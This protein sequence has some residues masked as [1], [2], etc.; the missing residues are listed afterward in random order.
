[1]TNHSTTRVTMKE[2]RKYDFFLCAN[3][4]ALAYRP[5]ANALMDSDCSDFM[6]YKIP[7]NGNK[8]LLH[9]E[10]WDDIIS[11]PEATYEALHLNLSKKKK[12]FVLDP[13]LDKRDTF[14]ERDK[15]LN[16][17]PK[18]K[19]EEDK[20]GIYLEKILR[21]FKTSVESRN[22]LDYGYPFETCINRFLS[23]RIKSTKP[24][25][26]LQKQELKNK[27]KAL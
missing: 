19:K 14:T 13:S 18:Q 4:E 8:E 24:L 23:I 9:E 3:K 2:D 12:K 7:L 27:F 17:K 5:D 25:T 6:V 10:K 11:I 22:Y 1:M 26:E 21:M 20:D 15:K 16:R